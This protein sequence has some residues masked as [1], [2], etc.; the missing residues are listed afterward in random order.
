MLGYEKLLTLISPHFTGTN[1]PAA[2][3]SSLN[4]SHQ[5]KS[6]SVTASLTL[7]PLVAGSLARTISATLISP[8]EMFRTRL[9]ALPLGEY[10]HSRIQQMLILDGT[11]PTY[12]SVAKQMSGL[13]NEKGVSILWRGLGPT[14]WRDVPFSGKS[15][16]TDSIH[17]ADANTQASIG[18]VLRSSSPNC[19]LTRHHFH[20]SRPS[21]PHSCQEPYQAPCPPS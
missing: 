3:S 1:D 5:S 18:W 2:N 10:G 8:I 16:R 11:T 4:R 6:N 17:K 7:A 19:L 20:R 12:S 9:Q 13:V 21:P 15:D 14:L